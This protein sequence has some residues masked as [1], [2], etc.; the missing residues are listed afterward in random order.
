[1]TIAMTYR[2][3]GLISFDFV[4]ENKTFLFRFRALIKQCFFSLGF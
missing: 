2:D 1:M 3:G 4:D